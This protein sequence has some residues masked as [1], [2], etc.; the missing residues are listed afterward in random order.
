MDERFEHLLD[1][2][3]NGSMKWERAYLTRR[4]GIDTD[5]DI[6]P[7]FIADMDYQMDS[8]IYA[9]L[10]EQLQQPDFGYFHIQEGYYDSIIEWQKK[11]H[12]LDLKREWILASIGTITSLNIACDLYARD[13]GILMMTPVYGSFQKCAVVGHCTTLPLLLKEQ[14]YRIDFEGMRSILAQ[15]KIKALLFCNPHNPSGRM[16]TY[17]ELE[18]LVLLCKEFD[19]MILSDEIHSDLKVSDAAF[20]SLFQFCDQYD[21][22]L[23]STSGNKTFNLSGLTT[24]YLLSKNTQ[25][26]QEYQNYLDHLHLSCNR[27]GVMMSELS[28]RY[29][30]DWYQGLLAAIKSNIALV[31]E[32]LSVTDIQMMKPE[33]GYLIWLYLPTIQDTDHF[34]EALAQQT[35]VLIESGSRFVEGYEGWV[36]INTATTQTLL[37]EAMKRFVKFYQ[38]VTS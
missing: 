3:G 2:R 6:Y 21:R 29:G 33:S 30:Y 31:E 15:G 23:V 10:Q 20:V 35:H 12:Q 26:L 32:R 25:L 27:I 37:A 13:A 14:R 36:R 8:M 17:A 4:F 5:E 11:V 22:I 9:K 19:V 16:W 38:Q 24:S 18:Q 34:V 28:Y 1:R 7:L